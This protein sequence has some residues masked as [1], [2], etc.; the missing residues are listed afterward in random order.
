MFRA[1]PFPASG[2]AKTP[3]QRGSPPQRAV[4]ASLCTEKG[5]FPFPAR[6]SRPP[7][8]PIPW[9]RKAPP[10]P[11]RTVSP[12]HRLLCLP[13]RLI[14]RTISPHLH[15]SGSFLLVGSRFSHFAPFRQQRDAAA[16]SR[17]GAGEA[18][19]RPPAGSSGPDPS[20]R[21]PRSESSLT[22]IDNHSQS[23]PNMPK[24]QRATCAPDAWER[25]AFCFRHPFRSLW[26]GSTPSPVAVRFGMTTLPG[27]DSHNLS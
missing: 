13:F 22:I 11:A 6:L 12:R 14:S 26:P 20:P 3:R 1:S 4:P 16:D 21:L 7:P 10:F 5:S 2:R 15:L 19:S 27:M 24:G 9:A 25:P 23:V 18:R 17:D 8:A